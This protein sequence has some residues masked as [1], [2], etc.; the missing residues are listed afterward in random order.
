MLKFVAKHLRTII[1]VFSRR[2]GNKIKIRL[3]NERL[4]RAPYIH[5]REFNFRFFACA[6]ENTVCNVQTI[7]KQLTVGQIFIFLKLT[8][9]FVLLY[10]LFLNTKTD[11]TKIFQLYLLNNVKCIHFL[12]LLNKFK[13]TLYDF[14]KI[15]MFLSRYFRNFKIKNVETIELKLYLMVL[16]CYNFI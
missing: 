11:T 10:F 16:L 14:S 8:N 13:L 7:I 12:T 4:L 9:G 3:E 2:K 6:L 1:C 15:L 5:E